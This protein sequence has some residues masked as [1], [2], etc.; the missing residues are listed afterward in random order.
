MAI[1]HSALFDSLR[2]KLSNTVF[3]K[4]G[5]DGIIRTRPAKVRNPRTPQQ[6]T[7]RARMGAVIDLS[8][9]FAPIITTGFCNRPAR[10]TAYNMFTKLNVTN[11][12][13]DDLFKATPNLEKMVVSDGILT[14]PDIRAE[15][16]GT[17]VMFT[18]TP[19]A[20]DGLSAADDDLYAGIYNDQAHAS[21]L[22]HI[23]TRSS[24]SPLTYQLP[25]SWKGGKLHVYYF[26]VSRSGRRT[27]PTVYQ[28]L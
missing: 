28:G 1:Y 23:G 12:T 20:A 13:V 5:P 4:K 2:N 19:Q 8:R 7:Q 11:V 15:A 6:Q 18:N 17:S 3:Y 14:A 22:V 27:S 24:A 10:L 16:S 9:E 21:R 26:A 25:E